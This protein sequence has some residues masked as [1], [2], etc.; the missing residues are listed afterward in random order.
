MRALSLFTSALLLT[1]CASHTGVIPMGRDTFMIAKQQATGFPGLGNMKAEI[2]GEGSRHCASLGKELCV[3]AWAA[4]TASEDKIA[5]ICSKWAALRPEERWW[6]FAMTVAEAGMPEDTQR[7]WR[8]ALLQDESFRSNG[9]MA[10]NKIGHP[11]RLVR[12]L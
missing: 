7:G 3:L 8:R 11:D 6:L 10:I 9:G 1:A 2:I 5:V 4:E 12:A